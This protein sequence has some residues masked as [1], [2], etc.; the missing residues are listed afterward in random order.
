MG[1]GKGSGS[2]QLL[3]V[4]DSES[5][6]WIWLLLLLFY[7]MSGYVAWWH[8]SDGGHNHKGHILFNGIFK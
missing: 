3:T 7:C 1:D 2:R 4:G 6:G 8:D 5:E